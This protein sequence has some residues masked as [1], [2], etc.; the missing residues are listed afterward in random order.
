MSVTYI[1]PK[2]SVLTPFF[3]IKCS[4][5]GIAHYAGRGSGRRRE[6]WYWRE[7]IDVA[8]HYKRD[9]AFLA[10]KLASRMLDRRV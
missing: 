6:T 1:M 2:V 4:C 8:Q 7:D 10:F 9:E 3:I 5:G